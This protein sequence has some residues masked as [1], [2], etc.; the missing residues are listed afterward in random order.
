MKTP[1]ITPAQILAIVSGILGLAAAFGFSLDTAQ[2]GE[3]LGLV[4]ILASVLL[5]SDA[6]IRNGRA[7]VVV[8]Q[9]DAHV[10]DVFLAHATSANA[11]PGTPA[12][13][14]APGAVHG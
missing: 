11:V 5:H 8:A 9:V 6:K 14:D 10:Q 13:P 12:D 7:A 3:I 4:G 1:D 2:Q